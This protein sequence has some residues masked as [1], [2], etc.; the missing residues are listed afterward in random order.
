MNGSYRY[1]VRAVYT[2]N[3]LSETAFSNTIAYQEFVP[4]ISAL[5][6]EVDGDVVTLNWQWVNRSITNGKLTRVGE[7]RDK[8]LEELSRVFEGFKITRNG[9]IIAEGIME[10]E[11]IDEG[12]AAGE[13]TYTVIGEF[14]N[15][16]TNILSATAVVTVGIN[17]DTPFE[18]YVTTLGNNYPN[19]FNPDTK[20]SYSLAEESAVEITIYNIK[21]QY[22]ATLVNEIQLPGKYEIVW[23]G[24]DGFNREVSSGIYLYRMKSGSY[25]STKKMIMMK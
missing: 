3:V 9:P 24:R 18:P 8:R 4:N 1:A 19:P 7:Q 5:E 20:I 14:T 17:D 6:A 11:Y 2:N 22:I 12:L 23:N 21:G 16:A 15:G 10:T 25:T 13:Y